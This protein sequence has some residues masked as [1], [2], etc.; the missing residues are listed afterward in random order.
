M[1]LKDTLL[2]LLVVAIWGVGFVVMQAGLQHLPPLLLG[3]LR[4]LLLALPAVFLLPRPALPAHTLILYGLLIGFGQ[5]TFLFFALQGG[6]SAG[7]AAMLLQL[8]LLFTLLLGALLFGERI[9]SSQIIALLFVLTGLALLLHPG[10]TGL[11][12]SRGV[13]LLGLGAALC[14]ALGNLIQRLR[15]RDNIQ[16]SLP[17]LIA[18]AALA[19]I[20]PFF[21]AAWLF[22]G[23]QATL[24]SLRTLDFSVLLA[25]IYLAYIATHL[26]Y[27]IWG[28][29]LLR[30]RTTH[31]MPFTLLIP[32]VALGADLLIYGDRFSPAQLY[33]LLL[34]L[35]GL[36][37]AVLGNRLIDFRLVRH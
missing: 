17:A 9:R 25:L 31:L 12:L 21:L 26:A 4:C 5:F 2:A 13:I 37:L 28:R 19:P 36:A 10:L 8:Q 29:L 20:I 30:N 32:L 34:I 6:L 24:T 11:P 22:N 14:L 35:L 15:I 33:S 18:R 1:G 23:A 27:A 16:G 3:G 7:V